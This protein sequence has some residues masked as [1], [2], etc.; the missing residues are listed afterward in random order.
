MA[1]LLEQLDVPMGRVLYVQTSMDWIQR[2][3]ISA[4]DTLATLMEWTARGGTLAMPSY[5][6]HSTHLEYLETSP[7][8]DV[9]RT[10][11]SIGIIPEM[12]RRTRGVVRSLDPDFAV[13]AHGAEAEAIAGTAPAEPDPFGPDSSYQRLLDRRCTLVGLGVSLNTTSFM[14]LIDARAAAGYPSPVYDE[15]NFA[16]TVIDRDGRSRQVARFALRP[17]F[18]RLTLPSA[19]NRDMQPDERVFRTIEIEGARFFKW[20]LDAWSSWCFAHAQQRAA[21]GQ[22]PCWLERLGEPA[23]GTA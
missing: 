6:F 10:P 16:T 18:Q 4:A 2:A 9:R 14:H 1:G 19:I 17:P 21:A 20:D 23:G 5:P 13:A 12:F 15:R 3:G 8:F 11:A 22:W 7:V